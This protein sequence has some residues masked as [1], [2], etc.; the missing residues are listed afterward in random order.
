M[1]VHWT[2]AA[3]AKDQGKGQRI[4]QMMLLPWK[5]SLDNPYVMK[6]AYVVLADL[7]PQFLPDPTTNEQRKKLTEDMKMQ[8]QCLCLQALEYL[9]TL[10]SFKYNKMTIQVVITI[11]NIVGETD[12]TKIHQ[13][14][15]H[16]LLVVIFVVY[17]K[18]YTLDDLI[19]A[20]PFPSL[21]R[22][23]HYNR[24]VRGYDPLSLN[25]RALE[26]MLAKG[27]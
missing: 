7:Y 1:I 8:P 23:I 14:T 13:K 15:L 21:R 22:C 5:D 27:A 11:D 20:I 3:C 17:Q 9:S 26:Q 24:S 16:K 18:L 4:S 6:C 12:W 25:I 19:A 2:R 10:S